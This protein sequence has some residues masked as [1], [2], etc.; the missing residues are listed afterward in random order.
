MKIRE[1]LWF[2]ELLEKH[3][4][5]N[6]EN[7]SP[8]DCEI[9]REL[10]VIISFLQGYRESKIIHIIQPEEI[11]DILEYL[12]E[13]KS[14]AKNEKVLGYIKYAETHC[15]CAIDINHQNKVESLEKIYKDA[16][17]YA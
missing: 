17:R 13:A 12:S 8:N 9:I 3:P 14:L 7:I 10:E 6:Y 15:K 4:I 1:K 11:P 2:N 5:K 16:S